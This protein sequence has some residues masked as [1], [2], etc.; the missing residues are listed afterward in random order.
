MT[1]IRIVWSSFRVE[2]SEMEKSLNYVKRFLHCGR[3]DDPTIPL[4]QITDL[5]E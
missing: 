5:W 3:N 2:H 1:T 4:S